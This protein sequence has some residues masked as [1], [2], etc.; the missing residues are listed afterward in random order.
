M[1]NFLLF[2]QKKTQT[3]K[4][5]KLLLKFAYPSSFDCFL[6]E[7]WPK[8]EALKLNHMKVHKILYQKQL[9]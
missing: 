7:S 5:P 4:G 9:K 2:W 6:Q 8:S 3:K 1:R